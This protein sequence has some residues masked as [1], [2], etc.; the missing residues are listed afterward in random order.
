MRYWAWFAAKVAAAG[1]LLFGLLRTINGIWPA[2][3]HPPALAPL[4]DGPEILMY[5]IMAL[6]WFVLCAGALA[7]IVFDQRRRCR[8]CLRR[9]RMPVETGSWGS[10]LLSGR[11]RI[12]YICPY[13]HG[14]LKEEELQASGI[15]TPEWTA[16]EGNLWEELSASSKES[17]KRL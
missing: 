10:V 4:R 1:A 17:D 9:L 14:T 11:P 16:H 7:A 15:R 2:E 3:A 13:G 6:G 12:E 8:V 5:N